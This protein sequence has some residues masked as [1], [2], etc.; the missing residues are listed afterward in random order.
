MAR[1]LAY[2]A[3]GFA[4]FVAGEDEEAGDGEEAFDGDVLA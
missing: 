1:F 2:S 3:K 4:A